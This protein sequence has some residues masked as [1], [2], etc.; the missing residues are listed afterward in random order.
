MSGTL[1]YYSKFAFFIFFLPA[2]SRVLSP[3]LSAVQ[4]K[5]T[6][7]NSLPS[8][9]VL[10]PKQFRK[11]SGTWFRQIISSNIKDHRTT[12]IRQ[13]T[14]CRALH[15]LLMEIKECINVMQHHTSQNISSRP[16]K[17]HMWIKIAKCT[18]Y[19]LPTT[20]CICF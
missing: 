7:F 6:S 1:S 11:S 10:S 18:Q 5:R 19:V 8:K 4:T 13:Q 9:F 2:A 3:M 12:N 16:T 14:D 20:K 15:Q 17:L